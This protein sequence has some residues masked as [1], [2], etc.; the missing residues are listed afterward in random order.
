MKCFIKRALRTKF[1]ITLVLFCS[2]PVLA[3]N[4]PELLF[5]QALQLSESGQCKEA[6]LT[7]RKLLDESPKD[8]VV[9]N[10]L[11]VCQMQLGNLKQ[12]EKV[13]KTAI[14][15][16]KVRAFVWDNL[17]QLYAEQARQAYAEVL[18]KSK[19]SDLKG[20]FIT[21]W[22]ASQPYQNGDDETFIVQQQVLEQIRQWQKA[23][24]QKD[25]QA[26]LS[27]YDRRF[28]PEKGMSLKS[29]RQ[30]RKRH[31]I[32][33]KYIKVRLFNQKLSVISPQWVWVHAMQLYQSNLFRGR[34]HKA[35][36]WHKTPQGWKMVKELNLPGRVQ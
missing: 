8:L 11:A 33:P 17:D 2:F 20:R 32:R 18:G 15:S 14:R 6:V 36:L 19:H 4:A 35:W 12:A 5:K 34:D 10:N 28:I 7:W 23:W 27:F 3:K 16:E 26:Y 25:V 30:Q 29:W 1:V 24:M 31:L 21:Q 22:Q 13:L 9:A